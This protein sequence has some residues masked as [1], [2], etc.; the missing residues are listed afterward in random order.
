MTQRTP[1]KRRRGAPHTLSAA[2]LASA[3]CLAPLAAA[4]AQVGGP[5]TTTTTKTSAA[6]APAPA[7]VTRRYEKEGVAVEF[8][9]SAVAGEKGV[10]GLAAGADAVVSFKVTEAGTKTPLADLHPNAWISSLKPGQPAP[11]EAECKDRIRT[12]MGGLLSARP[13]IDLN[14]YLLLTLNHDSSITF[15]NPQVSFAITKLES[16]VPLPGPG[17]DWALTPDGNTLLVSLPSLSSVAVIDTLTRKLVSTVET[18]AGT[19]PRRVAL[20]PNGRDLWV[21]LDGSKRVAVVDAAA[22]KLR[23]MPETGAGGLHSFAFTP[24]GREA[25]VS[26]SDGTVSVFDAQTLQSLADIPVEGTPGPIAYGSMARV[27]YVASV[28][29]ARVAVIDPSKRRVTGEVPVKRG[30]VALRFEPQGRYAFVVN[31]PES[32]VTVIDSSTNSVVGTTDV[33]KSPDQIVFTEGYAYV[34]G[35]GSEKFSLIGLTDAARGRISAVDVQAGQRP[36][37]EAPD[38]LGVADMIAATPEGNSAVIANAP[39]ATVYYYMQGM[40]APMGTISNYK[41]R[42]RALLVL[43]R[44]LKETAAGVYTAPVKL[45]TAGRFVASLLIDQPRVVTC[46]EVEVA[47]SPEGER[48]QAGASLRVETEFEGLRTTPNKTVPLRFRLKDTATGAPVKGL[49]DVQV[50]VFEPPGIWQQRQWAKEVG[51]G[52][53]EVTQT[54]PRAG[55]FSVMFR[56]ASRGVEYRH[57]PATN[58]SV[59]DEDKAGGG[60]EER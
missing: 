58:V 40:M 7:S 31:Q 32:T 49:T 16:I 10:K 19:A 22:R 43:D 57:L 42:P 25:Y 45:R 15:I 2:L 53:Y 52:V 60:K 37:S 17:A 9:L 47:D 21:A 8:T 41:R 24:D 50:L 30:T 34:R 56:V 6:A 59:M 11:G 14:S 13:D 1:G 26:N 46:F 38:D 44:S 27:L 33:A 29:G 48:A 39:D 55:L 20:A 28:N 51:E 3:L 12:F 23:G 54:F 36:P 5:A 18:G 35:V 4:R